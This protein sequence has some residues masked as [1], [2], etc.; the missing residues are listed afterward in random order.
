MQEKKIPPA[1]ARPS[2]RP[3]RDRLRG[4][5]GGP[6]GAVQGM[7]A[8]AGNQGAG[9]LDAVRD[10]LKTFWDLMRA[11][12]AGEYTAVSKKNIL[13]VAAALGYL[14]SPIDVL[15]DWVPGA[16]QLDDIAVI[17][18]ALS[19]IRKEL[20]EFRRW[21]AAREVGTMSAAGSDP[22]PSMSS[23]E[24]PAPAPPP[25][26]PMPAAPDGIAEDDPRFRT[27]R[28]LAT[29]SNSGADPAPS[30]DAPRISDPPLTPPLPSGGD[31]V[32]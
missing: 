21:K 27:A 9:A 12:R 18:F 22:A 13:L 3:D 10:D 11:W 8:S 2:T 29:Q 30:P 20:V 31:K 4:T 32:A 24:L 17:G 23:D 15:P 26:A 14:V 16:G 6:A 28:E 5:A 25:I 1:A 7:L 19:R